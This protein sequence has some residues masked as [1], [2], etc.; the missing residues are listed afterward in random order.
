MRRLA[1]ILLGTLAAFFAI[2]SYTWI[3]LPDVRSLRRDNPSD[4]AF[5]RLRAREAAAAGAPVRKVQRW[6]SYRRIS[7]ALVRAVLVAEDSAFW[8][9]DGLDYEE[10]KASMEVNWAKG[11]MVRGASTITQ[12]LS[13]NLYLSPTRNPYRKLTELLI[14]RR[15]EAELSKGR[16]LEIYLNVIEWGDGLWGVEAA[17]QRYFG[18]PASS[19]S[20]EQAALLA[21]AIINPRRYSPANPNARLRNRQRIILGRMGEFTP[22]PPA[23]APIPSIDVPI[24]PGLPPVLGG[25]GS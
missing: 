9:H 21:G 15:L 23:P 14:T 22:P 10:I 2:V 24:V 16:I 4:T 1:R 20:P 3:T 13:K 11:D 25:A 17:A 5:M 12:Q 18:V 6:V 8:Q 19:L 7:P